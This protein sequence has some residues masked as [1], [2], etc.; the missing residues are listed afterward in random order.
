MMGGEFD[1]EILFSLIFNALDF[2]KKV[3]QLFLVTPNHEKTCFCH[4]SYQVNLSGQEGQSV[5]FGG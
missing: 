5:G 4:F 1:F 2:K 3:I